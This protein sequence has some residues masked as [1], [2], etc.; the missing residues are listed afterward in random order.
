M[1]IDWRGTEIKN[2]SIILYVVTYS[3]SVKI[4]EAEVIRI[5]D[6]EYKTNWQ[7]RKRTF[8]LDVKPLRNNSH[9]HVSEREGEVR[10]TAIERVTVIG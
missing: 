4:V 9:G 1:H 8:S 2:G 10:I 7:N 3:S 6:E 5:R